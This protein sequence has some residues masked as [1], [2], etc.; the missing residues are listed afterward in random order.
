MIEIPIRVKLSVN[1]SQQQFNLV[2]ISE[3][4]KQ[5]DLSVESQIIT[6]AYEPYSGEYIVIPKPIE[7]ILETKDKHMA[8][9]VTVREIPYYEVSNISGV[10]VYI[11]S[12]IDD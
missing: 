5:F 12:T 6:T 4:K 11:G 3:E 8:D 1:E 7:Q 2:S 9:D 10:T